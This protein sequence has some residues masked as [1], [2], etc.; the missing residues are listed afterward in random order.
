MAWKGKYYKKNNS[1]NNQANNSQMGFAKKKM[2]SFNEMMGKLKQKPKKEVVEEEP[3][4][5]NGYDIIR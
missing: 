1:A 5:G 4:Y 2:P 3:Y